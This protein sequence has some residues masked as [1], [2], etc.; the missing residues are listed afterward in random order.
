M[1][2]LRLRR[3]CIAS[4]LLVTALSYAAPVIPDGFWQSMLQIREGVSDF[5]GKNVGAFFKDV[6]FRSLELANGSSTSFSLTPKSFDGSEVV[7]E[8][9]VLTNG[10]VTEYFDFHFKWSGSVSMLYELSRGEAKVEGY[11]EMH[12][13]MKEFYLPSI[14][15]D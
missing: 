6:Q 3:M 7:L 9:S 12:R 2:I 14:A 11:E 4:F 5:G 8:Y 15:T 13:I 10:V 1:A